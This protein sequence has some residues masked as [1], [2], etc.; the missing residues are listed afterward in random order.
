MIASLIL[1][2][3]LLGW[4]PAGAA[5]T[6]LFACA[7]FLL[8]GEF[9]IFSF[10]LFFVN[11]ALAA[12]AG[13]ALKSGEPFIMGIPLDWPLFYGI[14]LVECVILAATIFTYLKFKNIK[15]TTGLESMIGE[16]AEIVSW[17]GAH[18]QIRIQGEN[19]QAYTDQPLKLSKTNIVE[20]SDID[21]LKLKIK[22]RGN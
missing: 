6:S 2:C 21:G 7:I 20:I 22:P 1:G 12:Y 8:I 17:D 19:W 4:I 9:F 15:P 3:Y 16:D 18:G 10:G 13:Y 11:A 5:I 14:V